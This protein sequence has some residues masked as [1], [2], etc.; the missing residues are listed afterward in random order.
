MNAL[1]RGVVHIPEL[2]LGPFLP[3]N[4]TAVQLRDCE[5]YSVI[6]VLIQD[7]HDNNWERG[8]SKVEKDNVGVVEHILAVKVGVDLVPE[9]RE[10]PNDVL[11]VCQHLNE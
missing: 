11:H 8:E 1:I 9:K 10:C 4:T 5:R 7:T 2:R 3:L 6:D